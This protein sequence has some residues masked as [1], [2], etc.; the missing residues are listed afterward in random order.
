MPRKDKKRTYA[1]VWIECQLLKDVSHFFFHLVSNTSIIQDGEPLQF[2]SFPQVAIAL[3][4]VG[5][6]CDLHRLSVGDAWVHQWGSFTGQVGKVFHLTFADVVS[7]YEIDL[8]ILVEK[9]LVYD[10]KTTR[11]HSKSPTF[12]YHPFRGH[13]NENIKN[14]MFMSSTPCFCRLLPSQNIRSTNTLGDIRRALREAELGASCRTG[15][16]DL[17]TLGVFWENYG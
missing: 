14:V 5:S 12:I 11:P 13:E 15:Y 6:Q 2:T 4:T 17:D 9:V 3:S 1:E 10:S 8:S 16:I 7:S